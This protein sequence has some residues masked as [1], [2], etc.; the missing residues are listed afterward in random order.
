MSSIGAIKQSVTG[1]WN[2]RNARERS[3]LAAAFA[4][5]A[6]G[7]TYALLLDPAISG[8]EDLSQR[9]PTLRQQAAEVRALTR[10]TGEASTQTVKPVPPMTRDSLAASLERRG[11]KAQELTQNGELARAQF[12]AVSF[13]ALV[14]WLNDLQR[15]SRVSVVEAK[16]EAGAETDVV[17]ATFT[18]RQQRPGSTQ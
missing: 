9:L 12:N 6:L 8:R 11:I 15:N 5:V 16:V 13:S 18:F 3:M 10:E 1:F 7:L 2:E 14:E 17:N 4:V